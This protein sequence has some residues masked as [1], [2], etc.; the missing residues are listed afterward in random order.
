MIE[1]LLFEN[2]LTS[3][4]LLNLENLRI[5][6]GGS[7]QRSEIL[8]KF[9]QIEREYTRCYYLDAA[10][11]Q[12]LL[13]S[14]SKVYSPGREYITVYKTILD[15]VRGYHT[16]RSYEP[17][18]VLNIE[19]RRCL[20][21]IPQATLIVDNAHLLFPETLYSITF[22]RK[23]F[24]QTYK[25]K[26]QLILGGENNLEDKFN[27]RDIYRFILW[28]DVFKWDDPRNSTA[29]SIISKWAGL[30]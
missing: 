10:K 13:R 9:S 29:N 18:F 20:Q 25:L 22:D 12:E 28:A 19:L 15:L 8:Q 14:R 11:I 17:C 21:K 26:Y 24:T 30:G 1:T 27:Y 7:Q 16:P 2:W 5:C 23:S 6:Y 4:S 3:V